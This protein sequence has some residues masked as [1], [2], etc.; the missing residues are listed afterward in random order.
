MITQAQ[1]AAVESEAL[2]WEGTPYHHHAR[3]RG[4]GVDCAQILAA[5]YEAVGLVP[6]TDLGQYAPDWHLHRSEEVYLRNVAAYC[7]RTD[8][9]GQGDIAVFKYGRCYSHG[10]ILLASGEILHAYIGRGVVRSYP[11][12]EPLQGRDCIYWTLA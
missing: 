6:P 11:Y 1:R 8:T 12:E 9:P 3:I 10:G 2:R 4:V 5:V 7:V